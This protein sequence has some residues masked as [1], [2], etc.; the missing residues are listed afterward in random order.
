MR[1]NHVR[2]PGGREPGRTG[3]LVRHGIF[4]APWILLVVLLWAGCGGS[5][6]SVKAADGDATRRP[7]KP[8]A[9]TDQ[10]HLK[11]DVAD[12][13]KAALAAQ[14]KDDLAQT[15]ALLAK[16]DRKSLG[17]EALEKLKTVESLMAAAKTAGENDDVA[18]M[19][20]LA[21]K[22]RLLSAEL[23]PQ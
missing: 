11:V 21:R 9:D 14:A 16:I 12:E 15:T 2:Q 19:A 23:V 10:P 7:A 6:K 1:S 18:A 8:A 4:G 5:A 3:R 13:E 20:N 22:A 17:P